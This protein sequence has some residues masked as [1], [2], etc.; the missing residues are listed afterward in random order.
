[1]SE[2]PE[3]AFV[4]RVAKLKSIP[5][6]ASAFEILNSYNEVVSEARRI[7]PPELLRRL[8]EINYPEG[9]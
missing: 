4:R 1:M 6:G 5:E 8:D 9:Q 2:R 3:A 7:M